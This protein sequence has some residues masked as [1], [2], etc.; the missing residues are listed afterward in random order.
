MAARK[1]E[2]KA[3]AKALQSRSE[4]LAQPR[5]VPPSIP[6]PGPG[7]AKA[8][9]I[10]ACIFV[11]LLGVFWLLCEQGVIKTDLPVGPVALILSGLALAL[12]YMR[13]N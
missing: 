8:E 6:V 2:R 12:P 10:S 11:S 4:A 9:H 7:K 13:R 1:P 3:E 5:P